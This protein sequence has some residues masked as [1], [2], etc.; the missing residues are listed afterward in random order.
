MEETFKKLFAFH[1][2]Y[3][4]RNDEEN[5]KKKRKHRVKWMV[6]FCRKWCSYK[7]GNGF[8]LN[9]FLFAEN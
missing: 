1:Q 5:K 6:L 9:T 7:I 2:D 8:C 3:Y 4:T